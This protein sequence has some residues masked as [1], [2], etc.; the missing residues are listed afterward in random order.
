M[1]TVSNATPLISL[2]AIG[3]I[4]ILRD[5]FNEIII[6]E[7]VYTEIKTKQAYGYKEVDSDFI[8]VHAVSNTQ[9][10]LLSGN[11]LDIGEAQTI[12]LSQDIQA[13]TTIIDENLGYAIAKDYGLNV[14]RT[15]SI[16]LKAKETGL[17]PAVKP[18]LEDMLVKGRW[19]SNHVYYAFLKRAGEIE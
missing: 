11:E 4:E 9:H 3:K 7:A 15:L 16:L 8:T 10:A 12:V 19:Y 14:V 1:K 2:S 18:L 13:D 5:L 17:I 6:P